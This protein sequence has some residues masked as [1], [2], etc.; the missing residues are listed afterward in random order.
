MREVLESGILKGDSSSFDF[1]HPTVREYFYAR[2]ISSYNSDNLLDFLKGSL[3]K[4][5]FLN[6]ILFIVGIPKKQEIQNGILDFLEMN[7]LPLYIKCLES[8]YPKSENNLNNYLGFE[9]NF[10]YQFQKSYNIMLNTFFDRIK[11]RFRPYSSI[12][13]NQFHLTENLNVQIVGYVDAATMRIC[14]GFKLIK[15]S[16]NFGPL[17]MSKKSFSQVF[18]DGTPFYMATSIPD[19]DLDSARKM[20]IDAIKRQLRDTV[21]NRGLLHTTDIA[22]EEIVAQIKEIASRAYSFCDKSL[23]PLWK[24]KHGIYEAKEYYDAFNNIRGHPYISFGNAP[25]KF[26]FD[27]NSIMSNLEFLIRN[28]ISITKQVLP[29]YFI[30]DSDPLLG[31]EMENRLVNRLNTMYSI[32]PVRYLQIV[33]FNFPNLQK[34]M[35]YASMYPFKCI[36]KYHYGIDFTKKGLIRDELGEASVYFLPIPVG[37][38]QTANIENGDPDITSEDQIELGIKYQNSLKSLGRYS[39]N[40]HFRIFRPSVSEIINDL[41]LTKAL[42]EILNEDL[43]WFLED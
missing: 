18:D 31:D 27:I 35:H 40:N 11:F 12:P 7:N 15:V 37:E 24:F 39:N 13:F 4:D 38:E 1:I 26:L 28:N 6:I 33:Q 30:N 22:C 41:A 5:E 36:V 25:K 2:L 10:L 17:I 34:N 14:Y 32:L 29:P 20:A 43:G 19:L 16:D 23:E 21:T 3:D 8:R 9:N 42:Y